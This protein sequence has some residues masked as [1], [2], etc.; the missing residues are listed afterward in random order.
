MKK[1]FTIILTILGFTSLTNAQGCTHTLNLYDSYGDGWT[2]ATVD[3]HINGSS[4]ATGL[5]LPTGSAD[6]YD[7]TAS[8]GDVI[9]LE[10]W[11]SGSWDSEI[12]WDVTDGNGAVINTGT[13]GGITVGSAV[14]PSCSPPNNLNT[15]NIT[16]V[17][18][19]LGWTAGG[20]ETSWVVEYGS[21][22][23]TQG[24]GTMSNVTANSSSIAM[25]TSASDYDFYVQADCG[26]GDSS[27][28]AGPETFSTNYTCEDSLIGYCYGP[29]DM[30]LFVAEVLNAGD[31]VTLTIDTAFT[32]PGY[33][34]LQVYEGAGTSGTLL[35]SMDGAMGD[36][37]ITSTSGTLTAY[38][39]SDA[40]WN[41]VD[42]SGGLNYTPFDMSV[43]CVNT[44]NISEINETNLLIY[45]NPNNGD[46]FISNEGDANNVQLHVFNIQGK[47]VFNSKF[48]LNAG[49]TEMISLR[50]LNSGMYLVLLSTNNGR[51]MHNIVIQ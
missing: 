32:E 34:T 12:S 25:L 29:G 36:T 18:A 35:F 22:G 20:T 3:L 9:S 51:S 4:I 14:C 16:A 5:T 27:V 50:D 41:C 49:G 33:D 24:T 38:L 40:S 8:T 39:I 44:A 46:F 42:G 43:S 6:N 13:H 45:P 7:F 11:V 26:A 19:D 28:W 1:I 47:E 23:F 48:N 10:N 21:T 2:G 15:S 31:H 37:T 17:S 30:T